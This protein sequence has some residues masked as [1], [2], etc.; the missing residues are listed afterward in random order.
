MAIWISNFNANSAYYTY[1]GWSDIYSFKTYSDNFTDYAELPQTF[2][3]IGDMGADPEAPNTVKIL[4]EYGNI[5]VH[6][7][8][9]H[10]YIILYH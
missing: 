9:Y 5:I 10:S 7:M 8:A 1:V 2:L 4:E 3:M 6:N